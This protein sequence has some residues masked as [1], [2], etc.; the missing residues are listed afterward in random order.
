[1]L[2]CHLSAEAVKFPVSVTQQS[3]VDVSVDT[4][5][6]TLALLQAQVIVVKS[7]LVCL[8]FYIA[9]CWRRKGRL[10][11]VQLK[12]LLCQ[13]GSQGIATVWWDT[14]CFLISVQSPVFWALFC[15][16]WIYN[17]ILIK[18]RTR[19][20]RYGSILYLLLKDLLEN[21]KILRIQK[22]LQCDK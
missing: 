10:D 13:R 6:V 1:M 21:R 11:V 9:L 19:E 2:C 7:L 5:H 18:S 22:P 4:Y 16:S 17:I 15:K 3:A 20:M 14:K 8:F 12:A